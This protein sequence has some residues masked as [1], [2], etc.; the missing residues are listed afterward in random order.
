[1]NSITQQTLKITGQ[2]TDGKEAIIGATVK[3]KG[4]NNATVTD[5][6]GNFLLSVKIGSTLVISYVGY[7]TKEVKVTVDL[8]SY[9]IRR[10]CLS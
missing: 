2:V 8:S 7:V 3:E 1:M 4:T 6:D 5:L 10:Q 9:T